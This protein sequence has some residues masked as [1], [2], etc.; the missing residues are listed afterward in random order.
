VIIK[1]LSRQKKKFKSQ[2]DVTIGSQQRLLNECF[3]KAHY[4][5]SNVMII[6]VV[7][8]TTLDTIDVRSIKQQ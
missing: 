2:K 5:Q 8:G 1:A 3:L 7:T 6:M 4:V